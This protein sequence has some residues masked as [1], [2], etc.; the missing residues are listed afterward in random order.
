MPVEQWALV[1]V[2]SASANWAVAQD[3]DAAVMPDLEFIEFLG[4]MMRADD[5]WIDPL[6]FDRAENPDSEVTAVRV[7]EPVSDLEKQQ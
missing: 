5:G 3:G 1:V 7:D 2:L 4:T 6:D